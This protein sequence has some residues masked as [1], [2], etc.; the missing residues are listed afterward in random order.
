MTTH[1]TQN[2]FWDTDLSDLESTFLPN[3]KKITDLP[4]GLNN[5]VP[6]QGSVLLNKVVNIDNIV[7]KVTL[8]QKLKYFFDKN[9]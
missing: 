7:T 6:P 1:L 4:V 3:G 8:F 9:N 5:A 2:N